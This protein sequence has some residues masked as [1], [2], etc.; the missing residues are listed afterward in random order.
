MPGGGFVGYFHGSLVAAA[1]SCRTSSVSLS[2]SLLFDRRVCLV[3]PPPLSS[4]TVRHSPSCRGAVRDRERD[5]GRQEQDDARDA[6]T[7]VQGHTFHRVNK[8]Q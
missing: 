8:A 3:T 1:A 7:C 6:G 5:G 4:G 2:L